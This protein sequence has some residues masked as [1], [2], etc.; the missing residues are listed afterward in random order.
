[1]HPKHIRVATYGYAD[2]SGTGFGSTMGRTQGIAYTHGIWSSHTEQWSFNLRELSNLVSVLE[3]GA[4]DGSLI[5]TKV[6]LF[7][8]N[9]TSES[10]FWKGHSPSP[11]LNE[12]ALRLWVLEMGGRIKINMVHIPRTRMIAQGTDGLSC[13]DYT[14]GVMSGDSMLAHVPLHLSALDRQ[15]S[16]LQWLESWL[17]VPNLCVLSPSQWF[18]KGH[19]LVQGDTPGILLVPQRK[20]QHPG[21]CGTHLP[22]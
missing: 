17:P 21:F 7:T 5:D 8:D 14:E 6:W 11:L 19:G 22:P 9:S 3:E 10:V 18:Y 1:V 12:L 13:G 15:P 2:A 4:A 20:A 16:I